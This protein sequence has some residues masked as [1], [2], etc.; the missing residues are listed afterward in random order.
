MS[1]RE[2]KAY[3][4]FRRLFGFESKKYIAAHDGKWFHQHDWFSSSRIAQHLNGS[5]IY[6][7]FASEEQKAVIL[8]VD[9]HEPLF[10]IQPCLTRLRVQRWTKCLF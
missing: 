6:G 4:Q 5:K 2:Q 9:F 8:D 3:I 10:D 1:D 7:G